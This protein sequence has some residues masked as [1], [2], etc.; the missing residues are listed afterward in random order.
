[1]LKGD[2]GDPDKPVPLLPFEIGRVVKV[3]PSV[4]LK[5]MLPFVFCTVETMPLPS[6][7]GIDTV[8]P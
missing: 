4:Y 5:V 3:V 1:V 8:E 2:I 6:F 7:P